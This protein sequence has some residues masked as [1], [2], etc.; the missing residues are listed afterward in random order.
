M[1]EEVMDLVHQPLSTFRY[2]VVITGQCQGYELAQTLLDM[3][4]VH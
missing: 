3:E 1:Y 2:K 4:L